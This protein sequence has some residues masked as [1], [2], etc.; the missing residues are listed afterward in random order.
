[1][2][3]PNR[4]TKS[5][6]ACKANK[7]KPGS[8]ASPSSLTKACIAAL[9]GGIFMMLVCSSSVENDKR[10]GKHLTEDEISA[11]YGSFVFTGAALCFVVRG[12][13]S[14]IGRAGRPFDPRISGS[15]VV[16]S[17]ELQQQLVPDPQS[18]PASP[19]RIGSIQLP[20]HLERLP[21]II[22][23]A[24]RSG[25]TILLIKLIRDLFA[26]HQ[27]NESWQAIV[28]HQ[29]GE[30]VSD[31]PDGIMEM[32]DFFTQIEASELAAG[33][34]TSLQV[35][36]WSIESSAQSVQCL[37]VLLP[38]SRSSIQDN[39]SA[40]ALALEGLNQALKNATARPLQRIVLVLSGAELLNLRQLQALIEQVQRQQGIVIVASQTIESIPG[41]FGGAVGNVLQSATKVIL[42]YQDGSTLNAVSD[43]LGMQFYRERIVTQH[44]FYTSMGEVRGT[45]KRDQ[46]MQR[47]AVSPDQLRSL[48][49]HQGYLKVGNLNPTAIGF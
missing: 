43:L 9:F 30:E 1:M 39:S 37:G 33:N 25:K 17:Q 23:G 18:L 28:L 44:K 41:L 35:A 49:P 16:S 20:A 11:K 2:L 7:F 42:N 36:Q 34:L 45:S 14:L 12:Y 6:K 19:L 38:F 8:S 21:L 3:D 15:R 31:C 29:Q 5:L 40:Y 48:R 46:E 26:R 10:A 47:Y 4:F 27:W 32:S 24:E 13:I 22:L